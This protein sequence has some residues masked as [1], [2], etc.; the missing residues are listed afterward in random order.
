MNPQT[1]APTPSPAATSGPAQGVHP[2]PQRDRIGPWA[3]WF[4]I[5]GAPV[6]WSLQQLI[7]APLF[8]HGCYPKD[9]PVAEPIWGDTGTIAMA[10]ELIAIAIC[11]VAGL[12]AWRNWRRTRSEK[13]GSG[14]HLMASG[15]GRTRF[16]AMVGIICSGLFLLAVAFAIGLLLMIPPCN[17]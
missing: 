1:P 8:A 3:M 5:L 17:G 14:H 2:S 13:E 15:D 4:C 6:A 9:M 10:V 7:N 16:M 12:V 11:I